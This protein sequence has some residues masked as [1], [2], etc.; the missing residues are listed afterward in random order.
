VPEVDFETD[1]A[2]ALLGLQ[3]SLRAIIDALP[4]TPGSPTAIERSL[5]LDRNLAWKVHRLV[6]APAPA[7]AASSVPGPAALLMVSDA[8]RARGVQSQLLAELTNAERGYREM[9]RRHA[10]DRASATL[11][12]GA[13]DGVS[14]GP[15]L[16]L[17]RSAFRATSFLAGVRVRTQ[18]S[19]FVVAPGSSPDFVDLVALKGFYEIERIRPGAP[20][21]MTRPR[22]AV[23]NAAYATPL[24]Y[25]PIEP[26]PAGTELPLLTDFCSSPL[27]R[28]IPVTGDEGF[29]EDELED[30]PVGKT[31]ACTVVRATITRNLLPRF[32]SPGDELAEVSTR[33]RTPCQVVVLDKF[34]HEDAYGVVKPWV[35]VYNDLAGEA[36]WVGERQGGYVVPSKDAVQELGRGLEGVRTSDVPR[37]EALM[38]R[39]MGRLGWN[40]RKFL[41]FRV[42]IELP[43]IPATVMMVHPQADRPAGV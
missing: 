5:G 17:R 36:A 32:R 6:S 23:G 37:Y 27:P 40:P 26:P 9:I 35:R 41:A 7:A 22:A 42:T 3:R 16:G 34:V 2:S 20:F 14:G 15:D 18:L 39:V 1:A 38:E 4:D 12:M 43:L 8:A 10:G 29:V 11:M 28:F 21:V 33:L 25:G 31:G 30:R 24:D 13:Q 19:T